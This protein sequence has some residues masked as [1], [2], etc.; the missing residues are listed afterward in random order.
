MKTLN[1]IKKYAMAIVAGI[2]IM[3]FSSFKLYQKETLTDVVFRYQP[4]GSL[5]DPYDESNVKNTAYWVKDNEV[6]SELAPQEVACSIQVPLG[7]TMNS[8]NNI[9][10]SKVTIETSFHSTKNYGV[11]PSTALT[12]KYTNPINRQ[13]HP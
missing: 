6:C 4:P 13:L 11:A 12:P 5:T 3:G 2:A 7:N 10:P 1:F 9:D 8:G